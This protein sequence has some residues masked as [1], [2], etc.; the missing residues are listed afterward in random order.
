MC[1]SNIKNLLSYFLRDILFNKWQL[2]HLQVTLSPTK[3]MDIGAI[4]YRVSRIKLIRFF[5]KHSF[6]SCKVLPQSNKG[7][8]Y[9]A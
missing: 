1:L 8:N 3:Y 6:A 2:Q 4:K 7:A 5:Y 9:P